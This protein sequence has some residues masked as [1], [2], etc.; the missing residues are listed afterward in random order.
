M[1]DNIISF[2]KKPE[3]G[4]FRRERYDQWRIRA[5]KKKIEDKRPM[6]FKDRITVAE[7]LWRILG[8]LEKSQTPV[9]RTT[10]AQEVWKGDKVDSTKRFYRF[11]INP[12]LSEEEKQIRGKNLTQKIALYKRIAQAAAALGGLDV[13]EITADL[14]ERSNYDVMRRDQSNTDNVITE[15][16]E[17]IE[18]AITKIARSISTK[19]GLEKVFK[20]IIDYGIVQ[21][22]LDRL[23]SSKQRHRAF[24]RGLQATTLP[25]LIPTDDLP[26]CLGGAPPLSTTKPGDQ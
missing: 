11:V 13:D 22:V 17:D 5:I 25:A 6:G 19:Y 18:L 8:R 20:R 15:A 3:Q 24:Y 26:P 4:I 23:T 9:R 16:W 21:N 10:V 12:K 2:P 7:N 1:S 14:V